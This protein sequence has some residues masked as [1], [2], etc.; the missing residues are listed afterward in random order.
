MIMGKEKHISKADFEYLLD[1]VEDKSVD[2][3]ENSIFFSNEGRNALID[4]ALRKIASMYANERIS[5]NSFKNEEAYKE[6]KHDLQ[7]KEAA[8]LLSVRE[9]NPEFIDSLLNQMD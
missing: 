1:Y 3:F 9:E 8:I 4:A 5:I 6:H 7:D 2:E